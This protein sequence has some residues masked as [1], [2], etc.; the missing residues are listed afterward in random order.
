MTRENKLDLIN[1][2]SYKWFIYLLTAIVIL[3]HGIWL[4]TLLWG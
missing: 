3:F 1:H 4:L 2:L